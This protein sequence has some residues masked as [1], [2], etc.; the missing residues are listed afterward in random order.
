MKHTKCRFVIM[1]AAVVSAF[2]CWEPLVREA[3]TYDPEGSDS[4]AIGLGDACVPTDEAWPTFPGFSSG[5]INLATEDPQ[6]K[7]KLCLVNHFQGRVS[8]PEGNLTGGECYTPLG[9]R[10]NVPVQPALP[11]SPAEDS[12]ICSCRCDGPPGQGPFCDC[13]SGMACESLV[14]GGGPEFDEF[15]GSY[16]VWR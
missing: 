12:V 1:C 9:E 13:P 16:C 2:A 8:C 6:C 3:F 14:P 5:E 4:E 15:E 11:E 10:V 7:S